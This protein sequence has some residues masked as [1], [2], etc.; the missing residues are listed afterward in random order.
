MG[1][2]NKISG[3]ESGLIPLSHVGEG[4][5]VTVKL[6]SGGYGFIARMVSLGIAPGTVIRVVRNS[7]RG[8]ILVEARDTRVAIGR[9][10][11]QKV[12]VSPLNTAGESTN[13]EG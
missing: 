8:P 3:L 1:Q 12:L 11:A 9:G 13:A 10:A 2:K 4:T 5:G 7:G 6:L